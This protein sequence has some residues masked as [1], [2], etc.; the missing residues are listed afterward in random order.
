MNRP[1]IHI[2]GTFIDQHCG[3]RTHSI[4]FSRALSRICPVRLRELSGVPRREHLPPDLRDCIDTGTS[5]VPRLSLYIGGLEGVCRFAGKFRIGYV[6]FETTRLP[7]HLLDNLRQLDRLWVP[8]SWCKTMLVEQGFDRDIIDIV[9]EGVN[10]DVFQP[11]VS[12]DTDK[13]GFRFLCVGK[14]EKRKCQ[15]EL[16]KTFLKTFPRGSRVSLELHADNPFTGVSSSQEVK[17]LVSKNDRRVHIS[18]PK[19]LSGMVTLYQSA[20]A[21]VLPTRGEAWGL[22]ITEAMSTALP[23]AVTAYSGP[24]DFI[25]DDISYPVPVRKLVRV[26]DSQ[27]YRNPKEYGHWAEPDWKAL[28]AIMRHMVENP[29]EAR[30]KGEKARLFATRNLTWDLAAGKALQLIAPVRDAAS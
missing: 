8:T 17:K 16:V 21:F 24:L 6:V 11:P 25:R 30:I 19:N 5:E 13:Q 2:Y 18:N 1:E 14:W 9:P 3:W 10:T 20:D 22:P 27:N 15:A 23:C 12:R 26:K 7:R 29:R 4:E 28:S